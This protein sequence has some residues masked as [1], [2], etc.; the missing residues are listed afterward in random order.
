MVRLTNDAAKAA[1]SRVGRCR[2]A[3]MVG[4]DAAT[5]GTHDYEGSCAAV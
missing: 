2:R 1:E 4:R 5:A 3:V